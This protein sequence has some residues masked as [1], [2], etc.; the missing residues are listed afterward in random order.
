MYSNQALEVTVDS[1][2]EIKKSIEGLNIAIKHRCK[3]SSF[4]IAYFC[5]LG[6]P[7][8]PALAPA[9]EMSEGLMCDYG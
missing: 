3:V 6:R 9:V 7:L 2:E 1:A 4:P 5:K 8:S